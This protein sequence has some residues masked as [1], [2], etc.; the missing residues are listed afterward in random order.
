MPKNKPK[1]IPAD[2]LE[3]LEQPDGPVALPKK[4]GD[5]AL[6]LAESNAGGAAWEAICEL[7]K[8]I[9]GLPKSKQPA[10]QE[11]LNVLVKAMYVE[12]GEYKTQEEKKAQTGNTN[13]SKYSPAVI[14]QAITKFNSLPNTLSQIR[15]A[16]LVAASLADPKPS[17]KTILNWIKA[18]K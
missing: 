11:N 7:N 9:R 6:A 2:L 12:L 13:A 3:W 1:S 16:E 10:F 17:P 18:S 5:K 15:K 14:K 4:F 8:L